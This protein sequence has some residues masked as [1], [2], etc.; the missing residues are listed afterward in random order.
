MKIAL[1]LSGQPRYVAKGYESL[2]TQL[3]EKHDVDVYGHFWWNPEHLD[4]PFRFHC[5]DRLDPN[6][7]GRI[8]E[9][10]QPIRTIVEKQIDFPISS[11]DFQNGDQAAEL[12][13]DQKEFWGREVVFKQ[14]SMYYSIQKSFETISLSKLRKYD[15]IIRCRTDLEI[16]N[17]DLSQL[18]P[19]C[20]NT[21]APYKD[22]AQDGINDTFWV[23]IPHY[24]ELIL[25]S[26]DDIYQLMNGE[27]IKSSTLLKRTLRY[28][29][30]AAKTH[31]WK[32]SIIRDYKQPKHMDT[33]NSNTPVAELPFWHPKNS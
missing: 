21:D 15:F 22:F 29:K 23:M 33:Y 9:L 20:L 26:F 25:R 13:Q 7:L 12:G 14:L 8:F 4:K 6:D 28:H 16:Q 1:C 5:L 27:C 19:Y 31:D 2:K 17:L 3:L 10:Y 30:I 18:D 24:A 11:I 32:V